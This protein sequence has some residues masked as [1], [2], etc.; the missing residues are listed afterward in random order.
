MLSNGTIF[1]SVSTHHTHILV[2]FKLML[3]GGCC[4]PL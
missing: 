3:L 2:K 4:Y 1:F